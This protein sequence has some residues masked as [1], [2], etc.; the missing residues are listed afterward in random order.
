MGNYIILT[1]TRQQK[2]AHINSEFDKQE[3]I[4]VRTGLPSADYMTIRYDKDK[5]MYKDYSVLIDTKK[6]LEEIIGNL[7]KGH[8]QL[9]N[10]VNRGH[11][12][13]CKTFIFLI[14]DSKVKSA[15]D[16]KLKKFKHT[17]LTGEWLLKTMQTFK[18]HHDCYFMIVP[19][20][21]LGKTIINIFNKNNDRTVGDL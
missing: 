7:S 12:L 4:H 3:I 16:I 5:G 13:G 17:R 8:Q 14:A 20:K 2:E 9:V 15:E 21:D 18:E 19:R 11:E 6:D 10:E 1:D